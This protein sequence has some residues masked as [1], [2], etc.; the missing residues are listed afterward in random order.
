MSK[1]QE[2]I[3][4][5]EHILEEVNIEDEM[6]ENARLYWEAMKTTSSSE[7]PEFTD[8]GKMILSYLIANP[9]L[10]MLKAKD[11]AD[12]LCVAPKSISGSMRK[13][14]IDGYVEKLGENPSVYTLTEK[15]K[16]TTF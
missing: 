16:N 14:V 8:K 3:N 10:T 15:G 11:I 13:L 12:G 5:I 9:E 1:K 2:F 7:K 4:F 6:P